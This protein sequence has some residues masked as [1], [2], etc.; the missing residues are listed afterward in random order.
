MPKVVY[1]S[2]RGL[3]QQRGAGVQLES[4]P[5]SPVQTQNSSSGSVVFPGVYTISS[6]IAAGPLET[7]MPLASSVPGGVFVF[8]NLSADANFLTGSA[9]ATGT[10]VFKSVITGSE[11]QTQGSRL[12]MFAGI[13]ASVALI[14][15]GRSY[16]V[17]A[18]S[19]TLSITGT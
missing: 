8:R 14:S 12:A 4:T 1:T 9:E 15:D 10:R 18:N 11:A 3:F 7:I 17:M 6:S 16:L 2:G 5:F 13:G 19:G